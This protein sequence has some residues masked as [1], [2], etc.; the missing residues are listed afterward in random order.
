METTII[1]APLLTKGSY[2]EQRD[3]PLD[4]L[5]D[6]FDTIQW[7]IN[8]EIV[9]RIRTFALDYDIHIYKL[10]KPS[11]DFVE[12]AIQDNHKTYGDIIHKQH[13]HILDGL[14]TIDKGNSLLRWIDL[15]GKFLPL[16]ESYIYWSPN[17]EDYHTQSNPDEV[18]AE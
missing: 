5:E 6:N 17:G 7:F 13:A 10:R 12:F 1:L 9:L 3:I 2:K 16:F 18:D 14:P 15:P 8:D 11:L 4:N